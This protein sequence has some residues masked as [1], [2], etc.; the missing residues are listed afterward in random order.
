MSK[1]KIV[2]IPTKASAFSQVKKSLKPVVSGAIGGAG[3]VLGEAFVGD[4]L[5]A[6]VGAIGASLF[7]KDEVEKKIVIT[8]GVMDS[9]YR[10]LE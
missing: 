6:G 9:M 8:N 5:G 4:V 10:I 2:T 7:I 1:E 3:V